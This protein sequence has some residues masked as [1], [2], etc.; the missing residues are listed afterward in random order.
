MGKTLKEMRVSLG[1]SQN[2][3]SE[4]AHSVIENEIVEIIQFLRSLRAH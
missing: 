1:L 3:T 4:E 2:L